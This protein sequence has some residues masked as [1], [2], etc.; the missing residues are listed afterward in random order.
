[1]ITVEFGKRLRELRRAAG[2]TQ[3]QLG[4]MVGLTKSVISFYEHLERSP[5]P[6]VLVKLACVFHVS[7]DYLLGIEKHRSID[8]SDLDGEQ[9]R[10]LET[11]VSAMRKSKK[12]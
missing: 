9:I 11:M 8:I 1:M 5:S 6:S 3:A 10:L 4:E 7:T 2:Y 12:A